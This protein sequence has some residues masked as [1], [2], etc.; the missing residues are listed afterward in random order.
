MSQRKRMPTPHVEHKLVLGL[1]K[2]WYL[3]K[4]GTPKFQAKALDSRD[5]SKQLLR[6]AL[7]FNVWD[8]S[9]HSEIYLAGEE[10]DLEGFLVRAWSTGKSIPVMLSGLPSILYVPLGMNSI[11]CDADML[12]PLC[13][14]LHVSLEPA[15]AAGVSGAS[16]VR[17]IQSQWSAVVNPA[18]RRVR[19]NANNL[20][21]YSAAVSMG[22]S[23]DALYSTN[24]QRFI[25]NVRYGPFPVTQSQLIRAIPEQYL[26][27]FF[28]HYYE[29]PVES[30]ADTVWSPY[31]AKAP[32]D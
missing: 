3:L 13:C 22:A 31:F 18:I 16:H 1:M 19:A 4:D 9:S 11:V 10:F 27:N 25:D 29:H 14:E 21:A 30:W 20:P 2:H 7:I 17:L 26:R 8:G 5:D 23:S 15:Q 24:S 28:L 6:Y 12:I 32:D